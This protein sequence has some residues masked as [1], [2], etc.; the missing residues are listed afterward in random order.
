MGAFS[1]ILNF[2]IFS[3]TF[4]VHNYFP[5]YSNEPD[6]DRKNGIA[7][8]LLE[9]DRS[10]LAAG[11]DLILNFKYQPRADPA[12]EIFFQAPASSL[13]ELP[14]FLKLNSII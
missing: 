6:A 8:L 13:S 11:R 2:W 9:S 14:V 1:V 7:V 4:K 3:S 10:A 5:F 12:A